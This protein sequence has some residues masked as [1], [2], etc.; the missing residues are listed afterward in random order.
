LN[1]CATPIA[2]V[3]D[4][5][6]I[7]TAP[8]ANG[9]NCATVAARVTIMASCPMTITDAPCTPTS[10]YPPMDSTVAIYGTCPIGVTTPIDGQH[11]EWRAKLFFDA[12]ARGILNLPAL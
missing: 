6:P 4:A 3:V 7:Y 5:C 1:G 11:A 8:T 2:G 9:P 12:N 10:C